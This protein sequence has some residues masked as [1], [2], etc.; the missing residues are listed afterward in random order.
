[1]LK[2][3]IVS[4]SVRTA[5]WCRTQRNP[6]AMSWR[7]WLSM[8][9]SRPCAGSTMRD[10]S[11]APSATRT[12]WVRNGSAIA[13]A[14][15]AAPIGGPASWL[16]VMKP[17]WRRELPTARSWRSTSIGSSVLV[18]LS[19]NTSAVPSRNIATS[20][21]AIETVPLIT[22]SASSTSTTARSRSTVTTMSRRSRR[23]ATAPACRPKRSGG[24]HCSN[25]ASA[26]RKASWVWD[27]TSS[28]PA[29]IAIPSP[30]F[31]TQDEASSHRKPTPRR[32][33]TTAS[34]RRLTS[35]Q[36]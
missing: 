9:R 20:T 3:K 29:A 15:S 31:D 26:T 5:A 16:T 36:R 32:S 34:T 33:G 17:V 6:S 22:A 14:N 35:R 12:A 8:L 28:G 23:S 21:I 1:M 4:T 19:A 11:T 7:T 18:V 24:S 30:R 25:A 10:T 27:A 13:V 2:T